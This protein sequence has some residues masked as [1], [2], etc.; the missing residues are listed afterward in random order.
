MAIFERR[1]SSAP[2]LSISIIHVD[3]IW[4]ETQLEK[5]YPETMD[6]ILSTP[7]AG[8][9][10]HHHRHTDRMASSA[11]QGSEGFW[12]PRFQRCDGLRLHE[13]V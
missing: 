9:L 10:C 1:K 12:R 6:V 7:C 4:E 2:V 5:G 11:D 3:C 13:Q 8:L